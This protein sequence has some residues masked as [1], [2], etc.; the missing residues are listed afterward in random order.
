MNLRNLK[1]L[2]FAALAVLCLAEVVHTGH[3]GDPDCAK[4][5]CAAHCCLAPR[6]DQPKTELAEPDPQ[7]EHRPD[8]P[9]LLIPN[10]ILEDIF[11]PPVA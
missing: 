10:P 11:H 8:G 9:Q 4:V 7:P 2:I 3:A 5:G 6:G 1:R